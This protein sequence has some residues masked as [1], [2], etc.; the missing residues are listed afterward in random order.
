MFHVAAG[1]VVGMMIG[2]LYGRRVD[3]GVAGDLSGG[4]VGVFKERHCLAGCS[5]SS[6]Q[7]RSE[8]AGLRFIWLE[9][10]TRPDILT[11]CRSEE[12]S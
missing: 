4:G 10:M 3:G 6:A 8:N 5:P 12:P 9:G 1:C 7:I 11:T 2:D